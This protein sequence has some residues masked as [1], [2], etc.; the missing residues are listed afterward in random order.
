MEILAIDN[1]KKKE[2]FF[3]FFCFFS[4]VL[5]WESGLGF[6]FCYQGLALPLNCGLTCLGI[7]AS[8]F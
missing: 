1:N 8:Q 2:D 3:F 4:I 7:L 6:P 5:G